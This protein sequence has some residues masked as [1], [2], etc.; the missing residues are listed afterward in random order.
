[1][2][3]PTSPSW[4][5]PRIPSTASRA[6]PST[7]SP[8]APASTPTPSSSGSAPCSRPAPSAASARPCSPPTWR[9]APS[10]P[11]ELPEDK[12]QAGFDHLFQDDPFSGH[13]VIRST[14]V[15][16]PGS[17]YRLWTTLKVPQGYSIDKHCRHQAASIGALRFRTMQAKCLFRIG[18]G[19]T[20]RRGMEPGA[21]A[22]APAE[23]LDTTLVELDAGEWRALTALKRE[24]APHELVRDLWQSPRR[25]SRPVPAM[26]FTPSPNRSKRARSLVA[27]RPS[28]STSNPS[29]ATS[30]SPATTRSSTGPFR[31]G[32]SSTPAAKWAA[33]TS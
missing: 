15:A 1:M 9:R 23:V 19:H 30:A 8:A 5:S 3:P 26:S 2:T 18:V 22:D 6:T 32:K 21:R 33:I 28:W 4:R 10:S 31:S 12:L 14:D 16:I 7:R 24:F 11:G 27:S 13:V 29:P 17:R 20:R 25:R